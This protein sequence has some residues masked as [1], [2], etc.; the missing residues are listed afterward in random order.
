MCPDKEGERDLKR[1][2]ESVSVLE[3]GL[4]PLFKSCFPFT[5]REG[6]EKRSVH[7]IQASSV[8]LFVD[9]SMSPYRDTNMNSL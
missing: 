1:G 8:C 5:V 7:R 4:H 9:C 2:E 3:S 6:K